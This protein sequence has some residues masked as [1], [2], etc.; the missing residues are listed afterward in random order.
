MEVNNR[1]K[2]KDR[3]AWEKAGI[4]LRDMMWRRY[5]KKQKKNRDGFILNR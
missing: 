2:I 5:L 4:A 1:R 3:A